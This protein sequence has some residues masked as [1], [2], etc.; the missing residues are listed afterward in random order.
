MGFPAAQKSSRAIRGP[1]RG[2]FAAGA[3]TGPIEVTG[4][5]KAAGFTAVGVAAAAT[6]RGRRRFGILWRRSHTRSVSSEIVTPIFASD[7]AINRIEAPARRSVSNTSRNGSSSADRKERGLRPAA[8]SRANSVAF[9]V[10]VAGAGVGS[11]GQCA[12]MERE[13][14]GKMPPRSCGTVGGSWAVAGEAP[15]EVEPSTRWSPAAAGVSMGCIPV[16]YPAPVGRAT[17]IPRSGSKPRGLDVGVL[18]SAFLSFF[19]IRF[20]SLTLWLRLSR[21]IL[22][23]GKAFEF[24]FARSVQSLKL[25]R[26]VFV[27]WNESVEALSSDLV[28]SHSRS[29]GWFGLGGGGA[30]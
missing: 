13:T 16:I 15:G 3:G 26:F 14:S 7:C 8:I 12:S 22:R 23:W 24:R 29:W 10:E 30:C 18:T 9:R 19:V 6:R 17:G 5:G 21:W 27:G 4:R 28:R 20:S 2:V 11:A 25:R 1:R